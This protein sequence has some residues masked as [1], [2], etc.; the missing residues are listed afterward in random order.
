MMVM[1]C[2]LVVHVVFSAKHNTAYSRPA[3]TCISIPQKA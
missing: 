2:A 1:M 3:T